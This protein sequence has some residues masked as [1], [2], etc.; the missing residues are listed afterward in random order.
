MKPKTPLDTPNRDLFR[1]QLTD[2]IN[3]KHELVLLEQ[4]IDWAFFRE[5]LSKPENNPL[6]V[7]E[8]SDAWN[9]YC[10]GHQFLLKKIARRF[11]VLQIPETLFL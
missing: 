6:S 5:E 11:F 8:F 7:R 9:R 3:P 2:I 10:V 1:I 4:C